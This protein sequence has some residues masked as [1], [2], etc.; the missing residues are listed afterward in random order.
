MAS[1]RKSSLRSSKSTWDKINSHFVHFAEIIVGKGET[2]SEEL[3]AAGS[4]IFKH[5]F[6]GV[7]AADL[8]PY[9]TS[10]QYCIINLDKAS[11]PG[12]HWVA[13]AKLPG[14]RPTGYLMYDSFGRRT[15]EILPELPLATTDADK[16]PEQ[17]TSEDNCGARCI[18]WLIMYDIYGHDVA[19]S[20]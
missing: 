13:A 7:F 17:V 8:V 18:A 5:K 15:S 11:Q 16:D 12:S 9:S 6:A 3:E 4:Q 1:T 14:G 19:R 2:S 10:F 20:I